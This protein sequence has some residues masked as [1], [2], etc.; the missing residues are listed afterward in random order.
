MKKIIVDEQKC[1]GCGL[2]VS[3]APKTFKMNDNYKSVIIENSTDKEDVVSE[4][5]ASCPVMAI[6]LKD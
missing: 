3:I 2:C 1:I 4:A 6:S 5:I